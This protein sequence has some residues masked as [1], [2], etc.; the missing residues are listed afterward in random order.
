MENTQTQPVKERRPSPEEV[1]V[2]SD[3][4]IE[5]IFNN[6]EFEKADLDFTYG[7]VKF[8]LVPGQSYK[9]PVCVVEHLNGLKYPNKRY[10]PS[11]PQGKQVILD[12]VK[13]R[14][15]CQIVNMRAMMD[16]KDKLA[17]KD[18]K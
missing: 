18:D 17:R 15:N 5:V 8:H 11:A 12:G 3:P 1:A 10:D 4:K 16:A 2:K 7:G 9:L 6:L 13:H 14:F